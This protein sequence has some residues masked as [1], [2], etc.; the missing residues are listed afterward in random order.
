MDAR[1]AELVDKG[2]EQTLLLH[3]AREAS[4]YFDRVDKPALYQAA[5]H[6]PVDWLLSDIPPELSAEPLHTGLITNLS[7]ENTGR[8]TLFFPKSESSDM[9]QF[10][11]QELH[12]VIRELVEGIYVFN[13]V[14]SISLESNYDST[15]TV[16]I[17]SAY[18]D[19]LVGE[20]LF[21]V[22]YF[23]KSLLHGS[24]IPQKEDRV[25]ILEDWKKFSHLNLRDEFLANGLTM[26]ED[27][28]Q[29]G[30]DLYMENR[31][32]RVRYPPDCINK[33]LATSQL[34]PRLATGE[35]YEQQQGHLCRET[36]VQHLDQ[37]SLGLVIRQ[38][39]ILQNNDMLMM[40]PASEVVTKVLALQREAPGLFKSAHL[41]AYLQKQ[42]QFVSENLHKK[43]EVSR[44]INLLGF[45]SFM[46]CLLTTLKR[47]NKIINTSGLIPPR[48]KD[49]MRTERD[50]P[51][52]FP[53][54]SSRWSP[55]L[56]KN[57][58]TGVNGGIDFLKSKHTA[59]NFELSQSE[60]E[61][62]YG[63]I[64]SA[65][66][67]MKSVNSISSIERETPVC[68]IGGRQYYI[69]VLAVE[70]YYPKTPKLPRWVHAMSAELRT[71]VSRLP[72]LNDGRIQDALRK[73]LGPR[74]A[75]TLKTVNVSLQA[76]IENNLLPNVT[77][78]L[79]RCTRTR[80]G[81]VDSKGMTML[82]Y[83]ATHGRSDIA[84]ALIIAGSNVSQ[85][86][87]LPGAPG[88]LTLPIHLAARTGDVECLSC[89]VY[90]GADLCAM[91]ENG[92]TPMHHA[93]FH[94]YDAII[95]YLVSTSRQLLEIETHN[96]KKSTPVLL[97]AKNGCFNSFKCLTEL[98]ADLSST[99]T[100]GSN[101]V[102]F[103]ALQHHTRILKYLILKDDKRANVWETLSEM[104]KSDDKSAMVAARNLDPLTRWRPECVR[105]LLHQGA[106]DS[107]VELLKKKEALQLLSIQVLANISNLDDVKEALIKT[108]AVSVLV[109]LLSSSNDRIQVH[110]CL[111]ISDLASLPDTQEAV[112]KVGA[113][114]SL[115][116]LLGSD[117]DD[118][119][120]FSCA[121]I[122][123][124]AYDNTQNQLATVEHSALPVLVSMVSSHLTC[125]QGSASR[126]LKAILEGNWPNQ[127]KA[128]VEK[129]IPPLV[130]LLRSKEVSLHKNAA[131]TIESLAYNCI[132]SQR[133]LL[134]DPSCINLLKRLL[135]MRD[136]EIKVA[137]GCALWAIAGILI[138]NKRMIAT[139]MGLE[140][141]V[142]MLTL[143]DEKL[144]YVCSEAL[145]AL[146]TEL[147]GNQHRIIFIG[148][149]K[150]LVEAL[151]IP[152]S[153]RVVLSV[154]HTLAALCMKPA[155][156]PNTTAQ[157]AIGASRGVVILSNIVSA[158]DVSEIIRVEAAC[159][160]AKL[161][162]HNQDNDKTLAK[163]TNFSFLTIFKFFTS[164]DPEVRLLAG[165]CLAIMGFNS[166]AKLTKMKAIGTLNI[167]NFVPFLQSKNQL[168]QIQ[169][170]FQIVVLSRLLTGIRD[171]DAVV[172]GIKMLVHLLS[173]DLEQT[174]VLS[175][176][177]IA[178][179]SRTGNGLPGAL[180]MAAALDPLMVNLSIGNGPVIESTCV[181]L[182]YLTFNPMA[183]RLLIGMFRDNPELFILFKQHFMH[184]VF[185][186]KFLENWNHLTRRGIPSLR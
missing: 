163:H 79:K 159:A 7:P 90:Y 6:L 98:G 155:L 99:T 102:K 170:A 149:V 52:I 125:T 4:I 85:P 14:P 107:L 120:L 42:Q 181:A 41:H 104:L 95:H 43:T 86:V 143:H 119:Q 134:A 24:T 117:V 26:M 48:S 145:G 124:I 80:L 30:S 55:Y 122:G 11:L 22:D 172:K 36:F 19:S 69:I 46:M 108:D 147:G 150:P 51:P 23:V 47:Q 183:S 129:T 180:V 182:G 50:I 151:T 88:T 32:P 179:L 176:E 110:S 113:I 39:E 93:A 137:A 148:G 83:A 10:R 165:Y 109:K 169:A 13:Q 114:P 162:L 156:V 62:V 89:L 131:K 73:P 76:S 63:I 152:T 40:E 175:A 164:P 58:H 87:S 135:H 91:D 128:L 167:S 173:S 127:I 61:S 161:L 66:A 126:T 186:E 146:A 35:D 185:S 168:H 177:Y 37:V 132:E 74:R 57:N 75:F 72:Q 17:P 142:D 84:S 141:L 18:H 15:S 140:V 53:T 166:S 101:V 8:Y 33:V 123:I 105:N 65:E 5:A 171:V 16:S 20:A 21:A 160:L 56:S 34:A 97:A 94:N 67:A 77:A 174:K 9:K 116:Q 103:A 138:S 133:E 118:V 71:H 70:P 144:D 111:V 82:H 59:G 38:Q 54:T 2:T 28:E 136:P 68:E 121:C 27:D 81:K 154:I 12:Q 100:T 130:S 112:A 157:T 158:K 45:V 25:K 3:A 31:P 44:Y 139:H 153:H 96:K 1:R 184:I 115:I 29:L 64:T 60:M 106:V 92:W 178:S 49:V 78:L